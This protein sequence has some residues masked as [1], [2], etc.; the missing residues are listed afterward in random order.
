MV[1]HLKADHVLGIA[2]NAEK[3]EKKNQ[4][5]LIENVKPMEKV[6]VLEV[7]IFVRIVENFI[8]LIPVFRF[9]VRNVVR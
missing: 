5:R 3:S 7:R 2:P 1:R 4:L 6:G 9:I 8:R